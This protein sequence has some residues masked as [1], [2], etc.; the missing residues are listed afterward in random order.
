M[1]RL[2]P[3]LSTVAVLSACSDRAAPGA[4]TDAGQDGQP[5]NSGDG[6]IDGPGEDGGADGQGDGDGSGAR[7]GTSRYFP[8]GSFFLQDIY[9]AP[10]AAHSDSTI[11][12]LRE[13]GGWGNG[14]RFQIDFSIDVLTAEASAPKRS[15]TPRTE[16][17]GYDEEFYSP[18]C[19]LSAVPVPVG[20]N[21]EGEDGYACE[22]DGD[23]HLIV[24][25]P[26]AHALHE[27]WRVDIQGGEFIS[28]CQA[29]WDTSR[30][31]TAAGRGLQCSSA[32]AAGFPIAPLLFTADEVKAGMIDHA[33]RFILPNDRVRENFVPPATHGTR[34]TGGPGTPYYGV[35]FRLR[36]DYPLAQLPSEGARVVA[37]AL[38]RYG[39][40]HADGGQIALTAQSD[41]HTTAK[42]D[43][44]LDPRDLSMLK[45]EDF[46]VIDHGPAIE[47]TFDCDRAQGK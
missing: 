38:Q 22:S 6:D 44:L 40:Y 15:F 8:S 5:T 14:D 10:K 34:T 20:G 24:F 25:Q 36:R 28:G 47:L 26:D 16:D 1:S 32:D 29:R 3:I 13:H 45:V 43:D 30:A 23:C 9:D 41:R 42:W 12:A 46:E 19:D 4:T 37:R 31:V 7:M 2:L 18:D 17:N 39:M 21:I 11:K 35:H 27:L 33:I